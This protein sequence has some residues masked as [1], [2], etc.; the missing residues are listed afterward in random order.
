MKT[1]TNPMKKILLILS[2]TMLAFTSLFSVRPAQAYTVTLQQVGSNVIANGSGAFNLTGLIG[3]VGATNPPYICGVLAQLVTGPTGAANDIY[4]GFTGPTSFGSGG[5]FFADIGS[6]DMVGIGGF[7]NS[8]VVP[9]GYVSGTALSS[10]ATWN[11]ATFASLGLTPGTYVWTWGTGSANQNFTLIIA[12]TSY[13]AQI[14]QP[15]NTDGTSI[16]TGRR[17]VVPVKFTLTQNG[18]ATCD[19][20]PATI[21]VSRTGGGVIGQVN[22]SSYAGSAD[23]GSNFRISDCQYVYNLNSSALGVGI[24]H[25][26]IL[27]NGQVVGSATFE[28]R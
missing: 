12:A 1:I 23:S 24:Y 9:Q 2:I 6:G 10:T 8:L 11:N 14:Q 16:F 7:Y 15:I 21:A 28:L 19:L 17:G 13:A 20:P 27:I 5:L 3:P 4:G 26:D 18:V 22:E 25:L